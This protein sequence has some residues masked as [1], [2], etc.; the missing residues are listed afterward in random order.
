MEGNAAQKLELISKLK[1]AGLLLFEAPE[2]ITA[3]LGTCEDGEKERITPR[4]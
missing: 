4:G 1:A 3:A 2:D